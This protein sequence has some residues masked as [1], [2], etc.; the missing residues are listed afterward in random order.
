AGDGPPRGRAQP[1]EEG[2]HARVRGR[3]VWPRRGVHAHGAQPPYRPHLHGRPSH[4][5]PG[6]TFMDVPLDTFMLGAA[7]VPEAAEHLT[8]DLGPSPDPDLIQQ[9]ARLIRE[10][11]RPAVIA[12]GTVW[13]RHPEAEWKQLAGPPP[14]P[15]VVNGMARGVLPPGHPLF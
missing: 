7:D 3:G 14:L 1:D 4:S 9:A 15:L 10:A 6:P 11:E 5:R 13:W 8:A 12:G 2:R